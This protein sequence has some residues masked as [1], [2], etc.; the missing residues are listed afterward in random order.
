MR[1]VARGLQPPAL[2][3]LHNSAPGL[4]GAP[5]PLPRRPGAAPRDTAF[6]P[7]P[8][9]TRFGPRKLV[10]ISDRLDIIIY[11]YLVDGLYI[12]CNM[13]NYD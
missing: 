9:G 4:P 1:G 8:L 5:S 11:L 12:L 6:A 13:N 10:L 3:V 2:G 7:C